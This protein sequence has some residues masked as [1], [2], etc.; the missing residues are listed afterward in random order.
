LSRSCAMNLPPLPGISTQVRRMGYFTCAAAYLLAPLKGGRR[1]KN[2]NDSDSSLLLHP[3]S[4]K[5]VPLKSLSPNL[6]C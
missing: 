6:R 3:S 5:L 2:R 4:F 1:R